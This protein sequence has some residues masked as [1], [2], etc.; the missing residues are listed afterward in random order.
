MYYHGG[1][2][3]HCS[4]HQ[5]STQFCK[6]KTFAK[7]QLAL[8]NID[9][10]D[11]DMDPANEDR[12]TWL[13]DL[14][15]INI[16]NSDSKLAVGAEPKVDLDELNDYRYNT[17]HNNSDN[18]NVPFNENEDDKAILGPKDSKDPTLDN[19][20]DFGFADL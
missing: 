8:S 10:D 17:T 5:V 18:E 13:E 9:K 11:M 6:Q 4:T 16:L 14:E 12:G 20:E 2:V 3:G 1:R 19:Y 15:K 7:S